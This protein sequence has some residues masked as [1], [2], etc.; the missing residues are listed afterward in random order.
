M[1]G[2]GTSGNGHP[3][4]SLPAPA[5]SIG[6]G[7]S[8]PAAADTKPK[9]ELPKAFEAKKF[10]KGQS[11]NPAGAKPGTIQAPSAIT[12]IL[13]APSPRDKR[14]TNLA[15]W[16][17]IA[18]ARARKGDWRGAEI[19]FNKWAPDQRIPDVEVG[20]PGGGNVNLTLNAFERA[21]K[22]TSPGG[23]PSFEDD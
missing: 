11:G 6:A 10:K 16:Q 4:N 7:A 8:P 5:S 15:E 2:N 19:L 17:E 22:E 13:T 18:K 1:T 21:L 3:A 12:A 14:M 23:R 20:G 9:K